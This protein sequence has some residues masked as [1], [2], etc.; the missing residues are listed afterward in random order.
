M[1]SKQRTA[2]TVRSPCWMNALLGQS[3]LTAV[4]LVDA[5]Q[6]VHHAIARVVLVQTPR[7]VVALTQ[8][9][10]GRTRDV[11]TAFANTDESA[12]LTD[13]KHNQL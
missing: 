13:A 6:T 3:L 10:V 2:R 1:K 11:L 12:A 8:E 4:E 9:V 5:V 7:H